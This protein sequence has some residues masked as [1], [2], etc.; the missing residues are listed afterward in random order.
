MR[1]FDMG[2]AERPCLEMDKERVMSEV[3]WQEE[4]FL[5]A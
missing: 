4:L 3:A 2:G 5:K 1:L